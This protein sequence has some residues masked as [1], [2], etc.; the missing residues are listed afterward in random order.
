MCLEGCVKVMKQPPG[1]HDMYENTATY[2]NFVRFG[3][4]HILFILKELRNRCECKVEPQ[5]R[6]L[7]MQVHP[8][9]SL[10]TKDDQ[11]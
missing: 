4:N 2:Q 6:M 5:K 7:K 9:I 1:T 10:K 11:K 3:Q 8:T